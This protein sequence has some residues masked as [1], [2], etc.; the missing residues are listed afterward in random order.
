MAAK[1][2]HVLRAFKCD[3]CNRIFTTESSLNGH[4]NIHKSIDEKEKFS[5]NLCE[6]V[7]NRM[8]DLKKHKQSVHENKKNWFCIAR[9][10]RIKS[11]ISRSICGFTLGRNRSNAKNVLLSF[12]LRA[13]C[14]N[15][16][17]TVHHKY[18]KTEIY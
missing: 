15:I 6:Y 17:I 16:Q 1:R 13:T 9:I 12:E 3:Q 8:G 5:C 10:P 4:R 14:I 11:M 2:V 18:C 7:A